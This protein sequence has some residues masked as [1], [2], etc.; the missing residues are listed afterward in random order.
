MLELTL[1]SNV[2]NDPETTVFING[3]KQ[4]AV[5]KKGI[6]F[7]A[8]QEQE[9][10][11]V[12]TH[13]EQPPPHKYWIMY[14]LFLPLSL[15][16]VIFRMFSLN[17]DEKWYH[18]INPYSFTARGKVYLNEDKFIRFGYTEASYNEA[19]GVWKEPKFNCVSTDVKE[20]EISTEINR[21]SFYNQYFD[22]FC[23]MSM[24]DIIITVLFGILSLIYW[25]D[26]KIEAFWLM[27]GVLILFLC[28]ISRKLFVE[29]KRMK[30]LLNN[31]T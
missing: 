18:S 30:R 17:D 24:M 15:L 1:K 10:E 31:F 28:L 21:N 19:E 29:Y 11:I 3:E 12:F 25:N 8:E 26:G 2:I 22:Y 13:S 27:G 14:L 20:W 5:P 6:V 9:C 7:Y 23:I 16:R 4:K